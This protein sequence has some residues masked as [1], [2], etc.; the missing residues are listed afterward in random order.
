[1]VWY[2][3]SS[4]WLWAPE[5]Y[6]DEITIFLTDGLNS[7]FL[8]VGDP[9]TVL[10]PWTT[11]RIHL[12]EGWSVP[13]IS[14]IHPATHSAVCSR[15]VPKGRKIWPAYASPSPS[16]THPAFFFIPFS[17]SCLPSLL[18]P[19]SAEEPTNFCCLI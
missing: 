6:T 8:Q 4:P 7:D 15:L 18:R 17:L 3:T 2:S 13:V 19:D 12:P 1:M 5:P 9:I 14:L 16:S 11:Y 10:V